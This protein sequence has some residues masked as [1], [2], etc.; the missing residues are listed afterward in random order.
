MTR[1]GII[2]IFTTF[3]PDPSVIRNIEATLPQVDH[4]IVVDN[5]SPADN[6]SPVLEAADRLGFEVICNSENLGI[7]AALNI[8]AARAMDHG[9]SFLI[10]F[11][12]DSTP[13]TGMMESLLASYRTN[14]GSKPIGILSTTNRERVTGLYVPP[15]HDELGDPVLTMTSGSLMSAAIYQLAGPFEEEFFIEFVDHEYCLRLRSLGY[16]VAICP[17][18]VLQHEVGFPQTHSFLGLFKCRSVH[19]RPERRYYFTRNLAVLIRRY[20]RTES[21]WARVEISAYLKTTLKILLF[22]KR[23]LQKLWMSLRGLIDALRHT[24]GQRIRL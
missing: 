19:H 16:R 23:R 1:N 10:F 18:A 24:T 15:L 3:R 5:G 9:C 4:V 8:G 14:P 2:A 12:Q 22:E 7:G 20:G 6:L 21:L 11:D 17:S 13:T